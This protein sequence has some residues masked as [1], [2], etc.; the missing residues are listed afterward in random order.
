MLLSP[1]AMKSLN[2]IEKIQ[3]RVIIAT[4]N[5]NPATTIISCYSPTNMADEEDVS[6]FYQELSSLVRQ[7]PK[8]NIIIIGGDMNSQIGRCKDHR[9]AFHSTSNRNGQ[10]LSD[11]ILENQLVCLNTKY[12]KKSSKLWTFTYPNGVKAQLDYMLINKKWINSAMNAEA[13]NS[14]GGV[15]SDHRIVTSKIRLSL[16]ANKPKLPNTPIYN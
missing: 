11:F 12:Q 8:H 7:I 10:Y 3:P 16:R 9:Y 14:F 5:G 2:S 15:S 6:I 4:F 1:T 13:Y